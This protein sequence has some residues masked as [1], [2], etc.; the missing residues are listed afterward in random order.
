MTVGLHGQDDG[1]PIF[2]ARLDNDG[3]PVIIAPRVGREHN[4]CMYV[5]ILIFV[6]FRLKTGKAVNE[7]ALL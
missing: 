3:F 6:P 4:L 2:H 1:D 7:Q 5:D